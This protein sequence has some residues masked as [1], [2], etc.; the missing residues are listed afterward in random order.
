MN[1]RLWDSSNRLRLLFVNF[2]RFFFIRSFS[3][4]FLVF[5]LLLKNKCIIWNFV[6][7]F[8]ISIINSFS[9][10]RN[11]FQSQFKVF[12]LKCFFSVCI[13]FQTFFH[14][15]FS[16]PLKNTLSYT[17]SDWLKTKF[18]LAINLVEKKRLPE[19]KQFKMLKND[20][21]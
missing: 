2:F 20:H 19:Q 16:F 9:T 7:F 5:V 6:G 13:P 18:L 10:K 1:V 14:I 8:I 15:F 3:Q 12:H 4:L 11:V 17:N 21:L